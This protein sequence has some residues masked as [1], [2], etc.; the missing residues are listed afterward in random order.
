MLEFFQ[1]ARGVGGRLAFADM[2][3]NTRSLK[4]RRGRQRSLPVFNVPHNNGTCKSFL[5]FFLG[6]EQISRRLRRG[7]PRMA[8]I[9]RMA[10]IDGVIEKHGG[11]PL[12]WNESAADTACM[13]DLGH[14][15]T[16]MRTEFCSQSLGAREGRDGHGHAPTDMDAHG[17]ARADTD[18]HGRTRA[19]TDGHGRT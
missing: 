6:W 16:Q 1:A 7:R 13:P 9:A 19:D 4:L 11:W 14:G 10:E 12:K 15:R 3:K 2:S 17:R 8:R 5:K 18:E